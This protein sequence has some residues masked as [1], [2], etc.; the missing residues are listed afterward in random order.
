MGCLMKW[1]IGFVFLMLVGTVCLGK[2]E[3]WNSSNGD[4]IFFGSMQEKTHGCLISDDRGMSYLGFYT[5]NKKVR[6]KSEQIACDLALSLD[7]AGNSTIQVRDP[8]TGKIY[9]IDLVKLAKS[10]EQTA[11]D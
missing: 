1:F 3:L 2:A 6:D 10:L 5:T 11:Q 9:H 7:H 8:E 4:G